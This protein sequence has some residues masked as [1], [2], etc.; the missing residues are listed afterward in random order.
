VKEKHPGFLR[1][2]SLSGGA[3]REN[4]ASFAYKDGF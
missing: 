1:G 2:Y 3:T 4:W